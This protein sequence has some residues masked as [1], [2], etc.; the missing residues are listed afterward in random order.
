MAF[1][2]RITDADTGQLIATVADR[3]FAPVRIVDLN[4]LTVSSTPRE[5]SQLW[6]DTIAT[7]INS[8][9]F[10]KVDEKRFSL[11]SLW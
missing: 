11:F 7:A 4:K 2:A 8:D 3:K 1:A 6:A 10:T 5:I 9:G